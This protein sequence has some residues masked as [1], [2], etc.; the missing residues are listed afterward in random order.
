MA[1]KG[2]SKYGKLGAPSAG[3]DDDDDDDSSWGARESYAAAKKQVADNKK[4]VLSGSRAGLLDQK[5][6]RDGRATRGQ[7]PEAT[8]TPISPNGVPIEEYKVRDDRDYEYDPD[9]DNPLRKAEL[10]ELHA[11]ALQQSQAVTESLRNV[12]KITED[13]KAVAS[14]TLVTLKEQGEQ[15]SRT[16]EKA[17][18]LDQELA[19]G[20]YMLNKLGPIFSLGWKTKKT[21]QIT[22]PKI[23]DNAVDE[24]QT[25]SK[26]GNTKERASLFGGGKAKAAARA[27]EA[28]RAEAAREKAA[29]EAAATPMGRLEMEKKVQ[30]DALDELSESLGQL[31]TMAQQMNGEMDR[32]DEALDHLGLDIN[33]LDSRMKQ[34]NQRG[35]RLLGYRR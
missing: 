5:A 26:E 30:D 21:R 3:Y 4:A 27:A 6:K 32:Q 25:R 22:G 12:R 16:H 11:V 20:E 7:Q 2:A 34:S 19:K 18:H 17:V 13:T 28:A 33:E 8:S 23:I 31:K 15:I 24:G 9:S 1:A 35:R 10:E 14:Q 29:A